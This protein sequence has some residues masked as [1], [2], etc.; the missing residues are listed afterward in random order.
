MRNLKLR[1]FTE[2][3]RF[4]AVLRGLRHICL[5]SRSE[6][7]LRAVTAYSLSRTRWRSFR[8]LSPESLSLFRPKMCLTI[9]ISDSTEKGLGR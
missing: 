9:R 1:W 2:G 7:R 5:N 8:S 4:L 6:I 3:C